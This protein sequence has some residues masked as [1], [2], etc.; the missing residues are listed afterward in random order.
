M[1]FA[2][3]AD[4]S[5]RSVTCCQHVLHCIVA[6]V[7][8]LIDTVAVGS[9]VCASQRLLVE[10]HV[11]LARDVAREQRPW[12]FSDTVRRLVVR[13]VVAPRR[14]VAAAFASPQHK[15]QSVA[16]TL[17]D[18]LQAEGSESQGRRCVA[19][20]SSVSDAT[21]VVAVVT[22]LLSILSRCEDSRVLHLGH[23]R[24][25]AHSARTVRARLRVVTK[26]HEGHSCA[27]S[28][29]APTLS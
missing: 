8:G 27:L 12:P 20:P 16:L 18:L 29:V 15:E 11:A 7:V 5:S 26:E 17:N 21:V 19:A 6:V 14:S 28:R 22:A 10:K 24:L 3:V 13:Q 25:A 2:V 23:E 9:L 1:G 4:D